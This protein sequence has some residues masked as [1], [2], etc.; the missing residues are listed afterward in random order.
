MGPPV[1]V[2]AGIL[3]LSGVLPESGSEDHQDASA[4]S[5]DELK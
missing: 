1:V 2:T 3:I 4:T 5:I